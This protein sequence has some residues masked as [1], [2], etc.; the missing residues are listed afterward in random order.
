MKVAVTGGSGRIGTFIIEELLAHGYQVRN[1]D[2]RPPEQRKVEFYHVD[3]QNL[4]EVFD[5]LHGCDAVIH[6]AAIPSP[7]GYPPAVVYTNNTVANYNVFEAAAMLGIQKVCTASSVNAIGLTFSRSPY[8]D[9]FPIDEKHP[10]RVEDCYSLSKIV[11]EVQGDAFARLYEDMTLSSFRFHGIIL[12]GAYPQWRANPRPA[13]KD[14]SLWA[15]TDVRDAARACRLA[16]EAEWKGHEAFFI[17]AAD[18]TSAAPSMKLTQRFYPDVPV[19]GDLS[20]FNS[21]FHCAKAKE[22]LGWTHEHSWRTSD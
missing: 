22:L 5:S 18:T 8:Y 17:I 11:G 1:L 9:Y 15:Y 21:F 3:V 6:M 7:H 12:P 2:R 16:V 20:G 13:A 10:S 14:Q 4:G 19:T